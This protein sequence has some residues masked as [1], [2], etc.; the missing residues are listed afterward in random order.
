M[1]IPTTPVSDSP[2][3]VG[4]TA[5]LTVAEGE[6]EGESVTATRPPA[7]ASSPVEGE[8]VTATQ[9]PAQAS[10]PVT[11]SPPLAMPLR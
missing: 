7:Q 9:P 11:E 10:S 8:S 6:S 3:R 2:S 4:D 5:M 1:S